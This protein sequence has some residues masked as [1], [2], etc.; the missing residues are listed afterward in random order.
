[1]NAPKIQLLPII[2]TFISCFSLSGQTGLN[3][4]LK[5]SDPLNKSRRNAIVITEASLVSLT[6][7][8]LD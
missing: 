5:P 3:D 1:M 2:L 6:L 7:I 4:F 8:G